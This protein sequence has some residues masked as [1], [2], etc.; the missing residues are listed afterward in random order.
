[1]TEVQWS[2]ESEAFVDEAVAHAVRII[3]AALTTD[4]SA[5]ILT[6]T[7]VPLA[8][9]VPEASGTIDLGVVANDT[10]HVVDLKFGAGIEVSPY[11]N[12]QGRLYGLGMDNL[13]G[14]LYPITK[15]KFTILQPRR[16]NFATEELS[17]DALREWGKNVVMPAA[18]AAWAGNGPFVPGSHCAS[19]FCRARHTCSARAQYAVQVGKSVAYR[20]PEL[21]TDEQVA[22][23]LHHADNIKKWCVDVQDYALDRAVRG[24][25]QWPGFKL[26]ESRAQ[27]YYASVDIAAEKLASVGLSTDEIY[28]KKIISISRAEKKIGKAKFTALFD[29]LIAK[30]RGKLRLVPAEDTQPAAIS[31]IDQDFL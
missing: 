13:Y 18:Q 19:G 28:D 2:E 26:I 1:M 27:R 30:P 7:K 15:F 3:D 17:I 20:S 9:Y 5:V 11:G 24:E 16:N 22:A 23:I 10:I 29:G 8:P 25:K 31:S 21:L 12:T 6:E 14:H 4:P